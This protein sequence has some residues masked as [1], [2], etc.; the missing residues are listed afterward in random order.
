M[1]GCVRYGVIHDVIHSRAITCEPRRLAVDDEWRVL[2]H[3]YE[4]A[5]LTNWIAP[6]DGIRGKDWTVFGYR[7]RWEVVSRCAQG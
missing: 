6:G 3:S 2:M 7:T 4:S 1:E 5:N